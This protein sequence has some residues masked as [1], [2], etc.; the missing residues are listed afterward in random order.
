MSDAPKRKCP[1]CGKPHGA[2]RP[3]CR[4]CVQ[5]LGPM[6]RAAPGFKGEMLEI[7]AGFDDL[8]KQLGI[9]DE[10]EDEA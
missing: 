8:M 7:E 9:E 2:K 4:A 1:N 6:D 10:A 5:A 3:L